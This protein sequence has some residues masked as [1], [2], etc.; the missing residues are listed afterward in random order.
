MS[1]QKLR[2]FLDREKVKY[3]TIS[4]SPA[5]TAREIAEVAHIPGKEMAKTV[6]VKID[7]E[8]AMV[9]LPASMKVD[10]GRLLDATG[11][12]VVE[13]AREPEFKDLFP[14]CDLGAMPPFGN[15]FGLPTLVAEELTEDEEIAFNAGS[16]TEVIKLAYPDFERLVKPRLLPFRIGVGSEE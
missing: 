7:G 6:M 16:L 12:Q 11:A 10:F 4:H 13:L 3:V 9:V 5:F 14:G 15:L 2:D 1:L 8:M